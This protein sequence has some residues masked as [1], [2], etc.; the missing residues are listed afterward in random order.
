HPVPRY[1]L[2]SMQ[3]LVQAAIV[4]LGICN[5]PRVLVERHI[6]SG[7]LVRLLENEQVHR[8]HIY[9]V[10]ADRKLI[11]ARVRALAGFLKK[12]AQAL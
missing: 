8:T 10:L 3:C 7:D 1:C 11:P 5:A 4:G 9:L 6:E 2:G 12:K